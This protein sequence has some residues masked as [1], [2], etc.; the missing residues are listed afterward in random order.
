MM[1]GYVRTLNGWLNGA[2]RGVVAIIAIA[3][4]CPVGERLLAREPAESTKAPIAADDRAADDGRR[5]LRTYMGRTIA[6]FMD[7]SGAEWLTRKE[8]AREE[9]PGKFMAALTIKPGS[10]VCDF[11]CG[12]GYYTLLLAKRVGPRGKVYAVDIQQEMLDKLAERLGARAMANVVPVLATDA[13]PKLPV[14]ALDLLIMVDVYH[15]LAHPGDVLAAVRA[16]LKPR[17]RLVLAEF[18]EEDPAVP[19]KPLH[20]MSQAQVVREISANG[21]K[22][23]DQFDGLPWQHV[24]FFGR[25][26]S[27]LPARDVRPWRRPNGND[28]GTS[29]P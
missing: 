23:V 13:D 9:Q 10:I 27:P 5:H 24:L 18:R 28:D 11:G 22:L 2:L 17:G 12:N 7:A 15:E 19:I 3:V 14:A 1:G 4:L 8:R 26:D 6:P 20:K 21:F 29:A 25:D 16:S